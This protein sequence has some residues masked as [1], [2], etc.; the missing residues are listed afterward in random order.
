MSSN[1]TV[2][3]FSTLTGVHSSV[4]NIWENTKRL[5][6]EVGLDLI[7]TFEEGCTVTNSSQVV[8]HAETGKGYSWG[9]IF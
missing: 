3:T 9:W 8:L 7:G 2:D 4:K 5:Y 6:A 1:L